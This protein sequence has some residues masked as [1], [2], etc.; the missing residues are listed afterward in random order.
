MD[1]LSHVDK[2]G[3]AAMVDVGE[4]RITRRTAAATA[5]IRMSAEALEAVRRNRLK[6]GDVPGVARIAGIMAAKNVAA[7]IPLAH[8]LNIDHAAVDFEFEDGGILIRTRVSVEAKTGVEMEALTAASVAALAVYD[9]VKAVD[10]SMVI[11]DVRLESKSGGR[12]GDY[13]RTD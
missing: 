5:R 13:K 9:M 7:L 6:K 11:T 8:P 10:K 3:K 12:S 2:D 4:K 1:E